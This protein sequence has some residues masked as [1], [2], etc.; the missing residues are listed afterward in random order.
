[1][2]SIEDQVRAFLRANCLGPADIAFEPEMSADIVDSIE[3]GH[4]YYDP[5]EDTLELTELGKAYWNGK[6]YPGIH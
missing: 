5:K 1:M 2:L 6:E 4:V 3:D